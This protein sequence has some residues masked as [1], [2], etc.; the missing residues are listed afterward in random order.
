MR[1]S[2]FILL[3]LT[4]VLGA[5]QKQQV[6]VLAPYYETPE[7]VVDR[8]LQLANLRPG[9]KMFDLGSGDGRIVIMSAQK[10]GADATGIELDNALVKQSE[11]RIRKLGLS[12]KARIV[13]G[14]LLKQDYSSAD[15]ITVYL[16]PFGNEKLTPILEKQLKPGC[17]VISHNAEFKSW[18]PVKVEDIESDGEGHSHRLYLYQR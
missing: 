9:E 16:L 5:G 13:E 4:T 7:M 15:L 8:M 6:E 17:R 2:L 12:S 3:L 1:S 14:D 18:K 11:K 10:Y